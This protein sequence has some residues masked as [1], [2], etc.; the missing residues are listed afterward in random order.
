MKKKLLLATF[1]LVGSL[2]APITASANDEPEPEGKNPDTIIVS[3]GADGRYE[4]VI[5]ISRN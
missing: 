3:K 4:I 5:I 2:I 1:L